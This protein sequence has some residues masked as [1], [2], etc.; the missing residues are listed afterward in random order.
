MSTYSL[1]RSC[2][3]TPTVTEVVRRF[4][5][6]CPGID[7][8]R[9]SIRDVRRVLDS[10]GVASVAVKI[11][12]AN[13]RRWTRP[14]ILYFGP[15]RWPYSRASS[16]GHFVCFTGQSGNNAIVLDWTSNQTDPTRMI[17]IDEL[18]A[19]WEG[20][21]II[22]RTDYEFFVI[23][24]VIG[25]MMVGL[26]LLSPSIARLARRRT[27]I[28]ACMIVL[29]TLSGSGC[30]RSTPIAKGVPCL[31]FDQPVAQLGRIRQERTASHEFKFQVW[32]QGPV[33][34]TKISTSC[35]C[36]SANN[37][38]VG[39]T[40]LA[41][42]QHS[43]AVSV[44]RDVIGQPLTQLIQIMTDPASTDPLTVAVRYEFIPGPQ[45]TVQELRLDT[46]P[47]QLPDGEV[48]VIH[49]RAVTDA[50]V[51]LDCA[52]SL[53][54][55]FEIGEV[56]RST[57]LVATRVNTQ[58]QLAVDTNRIPLRGRT[59]A[60][61][62]T[63]RSMIRLVWS[64][65]TTN[66]LAVLVS[67]KLPL[68][69][70]LSHVYTGVLQPSKSWRQIVPRRTASDAVVSIKSIQSSDER[71]TAMMDSQGNLVVT[72]TAPVT[73]GRFR[74]EI[75]IQFSGETAPELRLPVTGIVR[76]DNSPVHSGDR[77]PSGRK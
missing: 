42:S 41:G 72:G 60:G 34:I 40:L 32:D 76:A 5:L 30:G 56:V 12:P 33:K 22:E 68:T 37:T 2:D 74:A 3:Q 61:E 13:L 8:Y 58:E 49:R 19:V 75:V 55:E 14:A 24:T 27:S 62:V 35:G 7:P 6:E 64:D 70:Q 23:A 73:P 29:L 45:P 21:A 31:V 52:A 46:I 53:S 20:E 16:T 66:D 43:I 9:H 71:M 18:I 26:W 17:L 36:T 77:S 1:L 39:Q 38:I 59:S 25:L 69:L 50:P 48:V 65:G 63:R 4:E 57:E 47:R 15:G 28:P 51:V 67:P 54:T 44:R 10:F 11:L